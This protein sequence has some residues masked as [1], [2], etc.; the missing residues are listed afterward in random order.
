M[1][2]AKTGIATYS[3]NL[4]S[5]L[6]SK[7]EITVFCPGES[8]WVA[9]SNC[10]VIDFKG[11]PFALKS[12]ADFDQII[13][14][15]GNNPWFHLD[16][17]K[18]F[19]NW[20]GHVVL[21][22]LVLYFLIAGLG[23][24]G[25]IKEF[26]KLY[27]PG[28]LEEMWELFSA[29]PEG[30]ILRYEK[31]SRYPY[32]DH[33]LK[34]AKS[35]IVHNNTSAK[36]LTE[37]RSGKKIKVIPLLYYPDQV[38]RTASVDIQGLR[39]ELGVDQDDVLL[40]IFGFIGPSKRIEYV[41]RATRKAL[42]R[43]PNLPIRILIVGEGPPLA[44]E[45]EGCHLRDKVIE[46][47]FVS[48]EK[49]ADYLAT[50]DIVANLRY[51]S[52][53]ESSASLIQA[54]SFAKPTIATNNASFSELPDNVVAK[55]SYGANEV[56]EISTI[57][58]RLVERPDLREEM[59]RTAR[60]YVETNCAPEKVAELYLDHLRADGIGEPPCIDGNKD[61][62]NENVSISSSQTVPPIGLRQLLLDVT[63]IANNDL[64]TGIER[65]TRSLVRELLK[66]PPSG[67]DVIPVCRSEHGFCCA[68]NFITNMLNMAETGL[69]N[70]LVE[71]HRGDIYLDL[72]WS[73]EGVQETR[74]TLE[75]FRLQGVGVYFLIFDI[76]P[77]QFPKYFP[78][79]IEP[80]TRQWIK[81]ITEIADGL[82]C[83]SRTVA[84][85]VSDWIARNPPDRKTPIRIGAFHLGADIENSLPSLGMQPD[86]ESILEALRSRPTFLM[87]GT[88]E[89][90]KGYAQ[91]LNAF[92][93]LWTKGKDINLVVVGKQGWMVEDLAEQ[94]RTN[95]EAGK[96]LF[97]LDGIS[98]EMLLKVYEA[99]TALLVASEGEGFGLPIIEGAQHG[100]PIIARELP[101]FYEVAGEHACYFSGKGKKQLATTIEKWL[102]SNALGKAP[103]SE[104]LIFL[105]WQES[106]NQLL[107]S[108]VRDAW[109]RNW[110]PDVLKQESFDDHLM[111]IHKARLRMVQTLL[112]G[113]EFILD[114]GGANSP[115]H[116]MGY[117][118]HFK[119]LTMI[120]LPQEDRHE[121]YKEIV[122]DQISDYGE[123]VIHYAD[124]T[125]LDA[126][127]DESVDFV[128]SGESIEHVPLEAGERMCREAYRV[129]K[130]GGAFCL[131][132]PNRLLTQIHTESIGGGFIHP[133]HYIEYYPD[134]LQNVLIQEGF[135][136]RDALGI[137]EMPESTAT[138]E[139]HYED[140]MMGRQISENVNGSY[141]Q[142]YHCVKK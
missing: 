87:V 52:M 34:K 111:L 21:H 59:G 129:L 49:F 18:V 120:D 35:V 133:E 85:Q 97:W 79:Y 24:G 46:L 26:G 48:D 80:T 60:Q 57:L 40:G 123:V 128:W 28:R 102:E 103:K 30:D 135:E 83:I 68:T 121:Y 91:A 3:S 31:P 117:T 27:G 131:D 126:F 22:D 140:F 54:L 104:S 130:K 142:F 109:Y 37:M 10:H 72:E 20:P 65:I 47:G 25:L 81:D 93:H 1:P 29:C 75:E 74:Q 127:E 64:R 92:Q 106:A 32:L 66:S 5:K 38:A 16:I 23:R 134:Q 101:V 4:I 19:L 124:M 11:D 39:T 7:A 41:L 136:I 45:I 122:V 108:L 112:P 114:L 107:S 43:N 12:L 63:Q 118:H 119:K 17:Y 69:E 110:V 55:V 76:L 71:T 125:S 67:F 33:L 115:L 61:D 6:D 77:L 53:G 15:F 90:R 96:R 13:Y 36:K 88:V 84:D 141:I 70:E 89:P 99:S 73:P 44:D 116:K 98:D 51:P 56:D 82:I 105:T 94:L 132:T 2:P 139:F 58:Q 62:I 95:K 14:H 9:P 42:N 8:N 78:P 137:C 113:G 50:V 138:G 100:L 86:S